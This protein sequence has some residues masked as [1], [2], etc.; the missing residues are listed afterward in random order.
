MEKI[1]IPSDVTELTGVLDAVCQCLEQHHYNAQE[2]FVA[3]LVLEEA[4]TNALKHGNQYN[5]A[6]RIYITY[7]VTK[8]SYTVSVEDEG[9]GF[10]LYAVP[11]PTLPENLEKPSGRGLLLMRHYMD[12]VEFHGTCM[13]LHK[14]CST[15]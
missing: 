1:S 14:K 5:P 3:R 15:K 6:K 2:L 4:L 8:E 13:T 9:A 7:S 10:D 11:D 12:T